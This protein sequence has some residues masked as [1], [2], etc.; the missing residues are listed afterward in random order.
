MELL[1]TMYAVGTTKEAVFICLKLLAPIAPF[2]TDHVWKSLEQ[3]GSIHAHAWP[4]C[5]ESLI[6][7]DE[8]TVVCQINGK[9]RDKLTIAINSDQATVE[10][11]AKSS[12]KIQ[13]YLESG[14]L[15]KTIFVPNKLINFVVS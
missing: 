11:V 10:S 1:N 12:D 3:P 13:T 7:D 6:Q 9:V 15:R 2:I 5:D 8:I 4:V 14:T